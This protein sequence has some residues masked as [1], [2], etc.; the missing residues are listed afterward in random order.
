MGQNNHSGHWGINPLKNTRL[1]LVKPPLKSTNCP[2]TPFYA[3]SLYILV[4]QYP[5]PKSRIFQ[6]TLSYFSKVTKFLGTIS[7]FEFL[8]TTKKNFFA[9]KLFLSLNISDFNLLLCE[10]CNPR[11]IKVTP[12]FPAIPSKSWGPVKHPLF[13]NL[14]G[15]STPIAPYPLQKGGGTHYDNSRLAKKNI[16]GIEWDSLWEVKM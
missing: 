12:C 3:I 1:F 7:Q 8:V 2:R 15:G 14:V 9:Y 16:S 10:N 11:L 5:P 13:E 4:F 6:W